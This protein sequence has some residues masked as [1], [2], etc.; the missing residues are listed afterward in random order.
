MC[1]CLQ[2]KSVDFVEWQSAQQF[3][4]VIGCSGHTARFFRLVANGDH[5]IELLSFHVLE[6]FA[7]RFAGTDVVDLF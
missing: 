2:S 3:G 4:A 7:R 1:Q 5:E 6:A